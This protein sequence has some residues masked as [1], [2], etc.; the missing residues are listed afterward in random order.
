MGEN[1]H[2]YFGPTYEFQ[3]LTPSEDRIQNLGTLID[4]NHSGLCQSTGLP[5]EMG[6]K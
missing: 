1:N 2:A 4:T 3:L 5:C 6:L